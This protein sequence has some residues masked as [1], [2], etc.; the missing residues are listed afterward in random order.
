MP[1]G[2][3]SQ[4]GATRSI[5][6]R[7][8]GDTGEPREVV[9][10]GRSLAERALPAIRK[11]IAEGASRPLAIELATVEVDRMA[12]LARAAGPHD[13]IAVASSVSSPD[14]VALR[15][16]PAGLALLVD[17]M[18]GADD[19][20]APRI[21]D[22][23]PS[24]LEL[25]VAGFAFDAVAQALDGIGA[26]A[27]RIRFPLPAAQGVEEARKQVW[28]DGP[29]VRID[30]TLGVAPDTGRLTVMMPQRVV[31]KPRGPGPAEAADPQEAEWSARFSEE[32]MRSTVRLEATIPVGKMTL[33]AIA[34]LERGQIIELSETAPAETR[35]SARD[36]TLFVCEFGRL[37]QNYTVRIK[38]PYGTE[39]DVADGLFVP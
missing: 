24:A 8:V 34:A 15:L 38:S 26:R 30:Y 12:N 6:E 36:R 39:D 11:G 5:L 21:A 37:G 2:V 25:D 19:G 33:G 16:D 27:L 13:A 3:F 14:A 20:A 4:D 23:E 17:A 22:R 7:L 31:L 9:K 18:F 29:S 35:L 32:V 10:S 28:R 1:G